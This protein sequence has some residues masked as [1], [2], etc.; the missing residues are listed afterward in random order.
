[1]KKTVNNRSLG[2]RGNEDRLADLDFADDIAL[3]SGLQK[4]TADLGEHKEKVKLRITYC[5]FT[6]QI[7]NISQES[8]YLFWL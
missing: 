4:M 5:G 7:S 2:I 8:G 3:L 1:M 6:Y